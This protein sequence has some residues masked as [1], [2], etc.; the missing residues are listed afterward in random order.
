VF[1][2]NDAASDHSAKDA[3]LGELRGRN[4]GEIVREDDE[5]G[6]LADLQFA[7]NPRR[8]RHHVRRRRREVLF[9]RPMSSVRFSALTFHFLVLA[10]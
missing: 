4:F 6:V 10:I 1:L 5:I 2:I 8:H 7:L 9:Q 3:G